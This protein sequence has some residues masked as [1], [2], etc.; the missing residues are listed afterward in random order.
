MNVSIENDIKIIRM[1]DKGPN[2]L[3]VARS[4]GIMAELNYEECKAVII[5]GLSLIHI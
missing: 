2:I 3:S 4:K 5:M 1:G